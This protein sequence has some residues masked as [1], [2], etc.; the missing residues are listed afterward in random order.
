MSA[1]YFNWF[2]MCYKNEPPTVTAA[3]LEIA[4]TRNMLTQ[5]EYD[6]IIAIRLEPAPDPEE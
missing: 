5:E 4:L 1:F 3:Q 2:M 6:Q